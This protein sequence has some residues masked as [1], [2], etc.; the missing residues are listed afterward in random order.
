SRISHRM[1]ARGF[2]VGCCTPSTFGRSDFGAF[3]AYRNASSNSRGKWG[4]IAP[5]SSDSATLK[6]LDAPPLSLNPTL[7]GPMSEPPPTPNIPGLPG[8]RRPCVANPGR[9]PLSSSTHPGAGWSSST[10]AGQRPLVEPNVLPWVASYRARAARA[11]RPVGVLPP[12]SAEARSS[13]TVENPSSRNDP[14][15]PAVAFLSRFSPDSILHASTLI[16]PVP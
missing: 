11:S 3:A 14:P 7:T 15:A 6:N 12:T 9:A 1:I 13:S 2:T 4:E 8:D 16:A 5:F 10:I